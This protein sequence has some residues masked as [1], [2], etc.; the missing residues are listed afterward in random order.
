MAS[1]ALFLENLTKIYPKSNTQALKS[2]SLSVSEGD[3]FALLGPN[4]AGKST[5]IGIVSSLVKKSGGTVKLFGHDMDKELSA[6]KACLGLVPQEFNFWQ[7]EPVV[8]ILINQAGYYGLPYKK[9]CQQAEKYLKK[10]GLWSYR[11]RQ[12][13][14]LSG[15]MKRRLMIARALVH[16]PR[17]LI[18][19]EPTAGV[20]VEVRHLMWSF[21]NEL[22]KKGVTIILTTHYFEEA[23]K[24][25]RNIAVIDQGAIVVNAPKYKLLECANIEVF[26]L[27]LARPLDRPLQIAGITITQFE[28]Q[29][30]EINIQSDKTALGKVFSQLALQGI[31]VKGMS[32]QNNM[33]EHVFMKL[34]DKKTR[35][36][37][38][39]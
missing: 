6:A 17:L 20:D 7:F 21:M 38:P 2:I 14:D 5:L 18:L 16:E 37:K 4:G 11:K 33:L 9:A 27:Y 23:E 25:C 28:P 36:T 8:E 26:T 1:P 34:V 39:A 32:S 29:V 19:D 13:R 31:D 15:G 30:L 35:G 10:M 22:N 3:F 12:A 24:M